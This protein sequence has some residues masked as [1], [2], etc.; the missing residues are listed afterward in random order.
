MPC[1][2]GSYQDADGKTTCKPCPELTSTLFK[3]SK[4]PDACLCKQPTKLLDSFVLTL[5][6]SFSMRYALRLAVCG[7][8]MYSETGTI[9]CQLCPRH[10]YAGPPVKG[11]YTQC[12]PCPEVGAC[13]LPSDYHIVTACRE[14]TLLD[15]GRP[16]PASARSHVQQEPSASLVSSH[17]HRVL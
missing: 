5:N 3:A 16:A 11:G 8:G 1:P 10:T 17:A 14:R 4:S 9:P 2:Q 12:E 15:S 13:C 7:N 6:V